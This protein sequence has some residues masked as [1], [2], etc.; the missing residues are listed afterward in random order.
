MGCVLTVGRSNAYSEL[1]Q[2]ELRKVFTE[3]KDAIQAKNFNKLQRY[4]SP[5]DT[6]YWGQCNTDTS[7]GL[8]FNNALHELKKNSKN[9][10]ITVTDHLMDF[11]ETEGW[12]G[13]YPYLYFQFDKVNQN[14]RWLG[15]CY[16]V[17]RSI[18]YCKELGG[19]E[20]YYDSPPKLPRQGPRVFKD[21]TP[22]HA[23]IAEILKFKAF[24]ALKPYAT[25]GK[26]LVGKSCPNA[27][28]STALIKSGVPVNQVVEFFVKNSTGANEITPGESYS[29]K[30]KY[31]ITRG[32]TGEKTEITFCFAEGKNGWEWVGIAY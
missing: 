2:Q 6:V 26:L 21:V 18:D 32:W 12:T 1:D 11:V 28:D 15:I 4:V 9:A 17:A 24:D 14:W 13:E 19:K 5:K 25:R 30:S 23:R 29:F 16:D 10:K 27:A 8:S 31:F 20:K 22:L 3:V 7:I